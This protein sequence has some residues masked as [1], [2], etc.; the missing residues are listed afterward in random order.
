MDEEMKKQMQ[1]RITTQEQELL[2]KKSIEI[3]KMLLKQG[4]SPMED[5][6][7][8]HKI[9]EKSIPYARVGESGEIVIDPE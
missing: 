6:K 2:R 3:N 5:P 4:H 8:L 1:L 7:L 9:L